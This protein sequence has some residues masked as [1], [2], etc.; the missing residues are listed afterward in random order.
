MHAEPDRDYFLVT[1]MEWSAMR[2]ESPPGSRA[3][4][5]ATAIT[6]GAAC[7]HVLFQQGRHTSVI[8]QLRAVCESVLGAHFPAG[9]D[10]RPEPDA[11]L[12]LAT[13]ADLLH[14]LSLALAAPS[15]GAA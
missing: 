7:C 14:R 11:A 2:A 10:L 6:R 9:S 1:A 3:Y 13:A 8:R 4:A 15:S 5:V 12:T